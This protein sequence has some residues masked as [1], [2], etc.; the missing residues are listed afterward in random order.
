[1]SQ[2]TDLVVGDGN[3]AQALEIAQELIAGEM[4]LDFGAG[5]ILMAACLLMIR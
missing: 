4:Q 5:F 3:H 1:M 2:C